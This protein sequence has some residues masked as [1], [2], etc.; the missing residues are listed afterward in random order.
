MLTKFQKVKDTLL[1]TLLNVI[2]PT[3]D[4]LT[5]L[6]SFT[7][8]YIGTETHT[9]CDE[10]REL[11]PYVDN[12]YN[13]TDHLKPFVLWTEIK[14]KCIENSS[15]DGLHYHSHP[16]WATSLLV[17]FLINYLVTWFIWWNVD[18]RK[19]ISWVA[20]LLSVYPQVKTDLLCSFYFFSPCLGA[21]PE[22][23][24]PLVDQ[25]KK[26]SCQKEGFAEGRF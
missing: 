15:V 18:K 5:D 19:T 22:S 21:S 8:L 6:R 13:R 2:W 3:V 1:I 11:I 16:I 26:G 7:N 10:K 20:P 12:Y 17:P 14:R 24:L 9:D 23:D 4:I 25:P